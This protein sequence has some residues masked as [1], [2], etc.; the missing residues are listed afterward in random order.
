MSKKEKEHNQ[1]EEKQIY[2][3]LVVPYNFPEHGI[4]IEAASIEEATK[5]LKLALNNQDND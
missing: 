4:T 1:K 3:P 5:K 2:K